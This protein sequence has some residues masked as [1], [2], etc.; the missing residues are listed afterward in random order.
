MGKEHRKVLLRLPQSLVR[1]LGHSQLANLSFHQFPIISPLRKEWENAPEKELRRVNRLILD[2]L[3]LSIIDSKRENYE[4]LPGE[5]ETILDY[6]IL[7]NGYLLT[8]LFLSKQPVSV[9]P[10]AAM[11]FSPI[12][13][14]FKLNPTEILKCFKRSLTL[15]NYA[16]IEKFYDWGGYSKP[17]D[18]TYLPWLWKSEMLNLELALERIQKVISALRSESEFVSDFI[19]SPKALLI[20]VTDYDKSMSIEDY[21]E[22]QIIENEKL[23]NWVEEN[24]PEIFIKQHSLLGVITQSREKLIGRNLHFARNLTDLSIPA[25]IFILGRSDLRVAAQVG[26]SI[27]ST[28]SE[29]L[30]RLSQEGESILLSN[31]NLV[32]ARRMKFDRL[33]PWA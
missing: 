20:L 17:S 10:Y 22:N 26:S 15:T 31:H 13:S 11:D 25:E 5:I 16:N 9:S 4:F 29:R 33:F 3:S 32:S 21:V 28:P 14:D 23:L 6:S 7:H 1:I 12:T 18:V 8:N 24:S 19:D 2:S 30:F 27:F